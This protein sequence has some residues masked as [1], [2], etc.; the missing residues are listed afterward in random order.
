[1]RLPCANPVEMWLIEKP[2][3]HPSKTN[4]NSTWRSRGR[5]DLFGA[6]PK[7]APLAL[8]QIQKE[9]SI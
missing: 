8:D 2:K 3:I 1:M 6:G 4:R 5:E 7:P 9:L